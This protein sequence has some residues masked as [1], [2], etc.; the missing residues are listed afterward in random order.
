MSNFCLYAWEGIYINPKGQYSSCCDMAPVGKFDSIRDFV[1]SE[2][3]KSLRKKLLNNEQPKVCERC[4]R[5]E[6]VGLPSSRTN[7]NS[8]SLNNKHHTHTTEETNTIVL[9]DIRDTNLCNMACRMCGS[10]CSSMWNQEVKKNPELQQFNPVLD[11]KNVLKVTEP[12]QQEII[13]TFRNNIKD[14]KLVYWAGGEPLIN[15]THWTILQMLLDNHRADVQ[16]RYN[17]NMLKLDYKGRDAIEEWK[18]FTGW[19]GVTVSLDCIGPRAEY[20]RHGTKWD[21]LEKNID[22]L[23]KDFRENTQVSLTT[24]IYTIDNLTQ[25]LDWLKRKG[26]SN[27]VYSNV[28]YTPE[29]LCI[30][31]LP[32][33]VKQRYIEQLKPYDNQDHGY[34]QVV[35]MLSRPVDVELQSKLRS[36]FVNYTNKLDHTRNQDIGSSCPELLHYMESWKGKTDV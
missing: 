25:T 30:D 34:N 1:N 19:V 9:W 3:M 18:K 4:W 7:V 5:K 26:V 23:L 10:F 32:T 6:N 22:R 33:E 13:D 15:D 29:Y 2:E 11:A 31:L 24:S 20:A 21:V 14:V 28:L 12:K 36:Q 16:L 8:S 17:T 35:H 27:V